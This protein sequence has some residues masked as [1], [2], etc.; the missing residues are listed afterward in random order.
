VPHGHDPGSGQP[1][2]GA[3]ERLDIR[4]KM[5]DPQFQP[6]TLPLPYFARGGER[7]GAM[8]RADDRRM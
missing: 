3:A 5:I 8:N 1:W 6:V 7:R 2:G 4:K